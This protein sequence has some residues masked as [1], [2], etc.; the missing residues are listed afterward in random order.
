ANTAN[1]SK[2]AAQKESAGPH[3]LS[4]KEKRELETLESQIA[5]AEIRKAE[6]E[7]QLGFHSRDAVK[8]QALF[9][10]QQQLLQ[11]LDRDMERW[12]ALAEKAEHEKRG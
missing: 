2:P 12:A 6:I 4:Y 1:Q 5:A 8:V 3:K 10:E 9:S 7:A 11:H